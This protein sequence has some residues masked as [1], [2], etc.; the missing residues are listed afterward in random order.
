MLFRVLVLLSS[1]LLFATSA[2][3][4]LTLTFPKQST[5]P[6]NVGQKG[7]PPCGVVGARNPQTFRPGETIVVRW[8]E[9]VSHPGHFRVAFDDDGKDFPNPVTRKDTNTTLPIFIDGIAERTSGGADNKMYSQELTFPNKPC[10]NC[11]LQVIQVMKVDPPYVATANR[12]IYYVCADIV[13]DGAP[14]DGGTTS[15]RDAGTTTDTSIVR[16]GSA[17]AGGG[18]GS[19]GTGGGGAGGGTAGAGGGTAG[20]GGAGVAGAGGGGGPGGG[21]G[22]PAGSGGTAGSGGGAGGAAGGGTGTTARDAAAPIGGAG[23][24]STGGTG[25]AAGTP[26]APQARSSGGCTVTRGSLVE[27]SGTWIA[28]LALAFVIRSRAR[29]REARLQGCP[30]EGGIL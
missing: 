9:T 6:G 16:D 10:T 28:L 18:G 30:L 1:M 15:P 2:E 25:G 22:T 13:L 7:P 29:R 23:G 17:G 12:D 21:G 24:T 5:L 4:H 19:T 11:T 14:A 3:A 20:T 8:T 27:V 26:A